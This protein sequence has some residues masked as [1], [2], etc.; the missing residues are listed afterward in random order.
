MA[1]CEPH[2]NLPHCVDRNRRRVVLT[3]L[4]S[5]GLASC[6]GGS[7]TM[8]AATPV[9]PTPATASGVLVSATNAWPA[10]PRLQ[11]T[12]GPG[13]FTATLAAAPATVAFRPG[14]Q[15]RSSPITG[16]R[17]A[18]SLMRMKEMPCVSPLIT[19]WV[20]TRQFIGTGFPYPLIRTAIRWTRFQQACRVTTLSRCLWEALAPIGTIRIRTEMPTNRSTVA[21]RASLL[22]AAVRIPWAHCLNVSSSSLI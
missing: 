13:L 7:P 4:A 20:R 2:P 17:P 22:C 16:A 8:P 19:I 9:V 21:S 5:L 14:L 12:T 11:S 15:P 10:M 3:G 6:G 18:R 1:D